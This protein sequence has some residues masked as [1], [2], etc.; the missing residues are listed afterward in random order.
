VTVRLSGVEADNFK[1][2][3]YLVLNI[4]LLDICLLSAEIGHKNTQSLHIAWRIPEQG[5]NTTS[6]HPPVKK[7]RHGTID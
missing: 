2:G 3:R 1:I 4:K 6:L 7:Y 5:Y